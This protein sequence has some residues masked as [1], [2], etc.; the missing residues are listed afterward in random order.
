MYTRLCPVCLVKATL[1]QLLRQ[2]SDQS[3]RVPL[4]FISSSCLYS[5]SSDLGSMFTC[6]KTKQISKKVVIRWA[7]ASQARAT[8]CVRCRWCWLR[9]QVGICCEPCKRIK[10]WSWERPASIYKAVLLSQLKE[11]NNLCQPI[12]NQRSS[13]RSQPKSID[14]KKEAKPEPVVAVKDHTRFPVLVDAGGSIWS[15]LPIIYQRKT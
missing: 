8:G 11:L 13:R 10:R 9:W 14:S 1:S 12:N 15:G 2:G 6:N 5:S 7:N 4:G 3:L